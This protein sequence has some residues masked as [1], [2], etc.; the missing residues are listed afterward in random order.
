MRP[1]K[2]E[3]IRRLVD[4]WV[5]KGTQDLRA[6]E[7]LARQ[8]PPLCY[9]ICFHCQQAAEKYL[10]AYLTYRQVEF[11]KTHHIGQILELIGTVDAGLAEQL[12]PAVVL[13]PYG[14]EVRYPGDIPEPSQ[15][16]AHEALALAKDVADAVSVRLRELEPE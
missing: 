2:H 14:V 6:A 9:P 4:E 15:E 11:T 10:K 12:R 5:R 1:P 13:T 8:E 3:V 7:I 16:Q